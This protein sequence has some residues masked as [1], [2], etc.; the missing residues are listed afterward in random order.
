[1]A[2]DLPDDGDLVQRT[3]AGDRNAF[4][5]LA[6]RHGQRLRRF[7]TTMTGDPSRGDDLAQDA[8]L[9]AFT[10]LPQL[11]EPAKFGSWL[12]A[13]ACNACR[14]HLRAAVQR[15]HRGDEALA[16][17]AESRRSALSSLVRREDAAL[18]ALAIDRLPI[19]LREA[20]V[21]FAVEGLPYVEIAAIT[22]ASENTLQVRVHRS[23]ALLRRQ[24]GARVDTWLLRE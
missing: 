20:F 19:L 4:A 9:A 7:L 1:V 22:G 21:L 5:S 23:K 10:R 24:L 13:I 14:H 6:E 17:V 11:T 2:A 16:E 18:L 15:A 8:L 3:R 12:L